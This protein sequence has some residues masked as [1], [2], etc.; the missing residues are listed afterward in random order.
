MAPGTGVKNKGG[1]GVVNAYALRQAMMSVS[2][3]CLGVLQHGRWLALL[4]R[5]DV[6]QHGHCQGDVVMLLLLW[7]L[8]HVMW[9][10]NAHAGASRWTTIS[11]SHHHFS[12]LETW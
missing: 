10:L 6:G 5:A 4:M 11:V 9:Q 1:E 2:H 7:S 8:Q 12:V 3:C